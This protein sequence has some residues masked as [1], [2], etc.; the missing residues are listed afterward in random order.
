MS[1]T[2]DARSLAVGAFG[3]AVFT[4]LFLQWPQ[5]SNPTTVALGFLVVV[6]FVA[7]RARLWVAV[8]LSFLSM[9]ALNFFF[10]PPVRTLTIADPQNWIALLAFVAASLVASNL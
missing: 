7:A 2:A 6:L 4:W 10:L 3:I 5:V 8:T 1:V 9:F